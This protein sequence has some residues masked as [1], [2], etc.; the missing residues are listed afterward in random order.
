MFTHADL[1]AK[2][3]E[4]NVLDFSSVRA[5]VFEATGDI[6][7]LHGEGPLDERLLAGVQG[8]EARTGTSVSSAG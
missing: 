8:G 2:L 6:S 1:V 3:R 7:V 4:A 5:V